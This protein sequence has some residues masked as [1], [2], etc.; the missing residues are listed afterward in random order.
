M[1]THGSIE[2]FRT[3]GTTKTTMLVVDIVRASSDA[4]DYRLK[5]EIDRVPKA[6]RNMDVDII[7]DAQLCHIKVE[8]IDVNESAIDVNESVS[9]GKPELNDQLAENIPH[10]VKDE[11]FNCATCGRRFNKK[12]SLAVHLSRSHGIRAT[13]YQCYVCKKR[14]RT[15]TAVSLHL[16]KKH[17]VQPATKPKLNKNHCNHCDM[18]FSS[19]AKLMEHWE[20]LKNGKSSLCTVCFATFDR[21]YDLASHRELNIAC[22]VSK[23]LCNHCGKYYINDT[24]LRYH[25]DSVHLNVRA[26]VCRFCSKAFTTNGVLSR[27]EAAHENKR[28]YVCNVKGCGQTFN[29]TGKLRDHTRFI[30]EAPKLNCTYCG[31]IFKRPVTLR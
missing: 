18:N 9:S 7:L 6:C 1:C 31:K 10:S 20:T 16:K 25:I 14:C 19:N 22:R 4:F 29:N 21:K 26:F 13:T 3:D 23:S 15:I 17:A 27:H 28:Q 12:V 11:G 24:L 30:H 5:L 8:S 2:E